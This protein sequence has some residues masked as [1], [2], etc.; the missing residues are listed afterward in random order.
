MKKSNITSA[1][2]PL[3]TEFLK[4]IDTARGDIPRSKYIIKVLEEESEIKDNEKVIRNNLNSLEDKTA[5]LHHS[6]EFSN[7]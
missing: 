3:P 6:S 7:P 4:L 5:N 2:I 1:G